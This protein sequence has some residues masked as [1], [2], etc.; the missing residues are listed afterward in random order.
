MPNSSIPWTR[1][2]SNVGVLG[3]GQTTALYSCNLRAV[4]ASQPMSSVSTK[5][6]L[7]LLTVTD[8][9]KV[10]VDVGA[11]RSGDPRLRRNKNEG[12]AE[13]SSS[14]IRPGNTTSAIDDD[15]S[16]WD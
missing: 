5:P 2:P 6:M 3:T 8:L 7:T 11:V 12:N 13:P 15:D 10:L 9:E 16:D 14:K 4:T 1:A